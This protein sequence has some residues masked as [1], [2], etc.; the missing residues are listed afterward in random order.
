[1]EP[2]QAA[3]DLLTVAVPFDDGHL[4]ISYAQLVS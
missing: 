4:A 1:M 3:N 2:H